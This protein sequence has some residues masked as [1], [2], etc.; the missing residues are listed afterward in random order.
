[1]SRGTRKESKKS[2]YTVAWGSTLKEMLFYKDK[3]SAWK[4]A[5]K[6]RKEGKSP[7]SISRL[8]T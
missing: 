2:K 6:L 7:V 5:K 8:Y 4:K 3:K 1:M